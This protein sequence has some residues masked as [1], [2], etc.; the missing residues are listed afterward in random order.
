MEHEAMQSF[1]K[2]QKKQVKLTYN[3]GFILRG[4]V[5][6]LFKDSILFRTKQH[7]SIINLSEIKSVVG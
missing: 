3:D 6:E 1:L 5:V 2:R 4:V 7:E